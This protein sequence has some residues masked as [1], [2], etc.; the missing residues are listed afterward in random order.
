MS[1]TYGQRIRFMGLWGKS[2]LPGDAWL[3]SFSNRHRITAWPPRNCPG[4]TGV[5]GQA[6]FHI[7]RGSVH[8][9]LG[10]AWGAPGGAWLLLFSGSQ[11]IRYTPLRAALETRGVCPSIITAG[12]CALQCVTNLWAPGRRLACF[13]Q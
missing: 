5:A 4:D 7:S 1:F 6:S 9:F 11:E 8:G 13:L 2:G 3:A 12:R 10:R